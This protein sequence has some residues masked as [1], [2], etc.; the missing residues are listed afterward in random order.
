MA[1]CPWGD[2]AAIMLEEA[3]E[4]WCGSIRDRRIEWGRVQAQQP[5]HEVFS[6]QRKGGKTLPD[7]TA[8]ALK[9]EKRKEAIVDLWIYAITTICLR[10]WKRKLS[11]SCFHVASKI[12]I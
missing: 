10:P 6:A 9:K 8:V 5:A 12:D 7:M 1:G 3:A 11:V 4:L 2:G